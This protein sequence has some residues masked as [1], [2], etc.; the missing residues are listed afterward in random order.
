MNAN[1]KELLRRVGNVDTKAYYRLRY[2]LTKMNALPEYAKFLWRTHPL[3]EP[4][5]TYAFVWFKAEYGDDYWYKIDKLV[6]A[7]YA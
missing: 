3:D 5:L 2:I 4:K 1:E 7:F 6:N